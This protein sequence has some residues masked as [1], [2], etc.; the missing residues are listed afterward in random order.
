MNV[1]WAAGRR[2]KAGGGHKEREREEVQSEYFRWE[3]FFATAPPPLEEQQVEN[4]IC[5]E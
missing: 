3:T 1:L 4:G 5:I 2:E